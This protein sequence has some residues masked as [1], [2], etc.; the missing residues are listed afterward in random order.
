MSTFLVSVSDKIVFAVLSSP[1]RGVCVPGVRCCGCEKHIS[2]NTTFKIVIIS[3]L[4]VN[5]TECPG[6]Y[7]DIIKMIG[8][9]QLGGVL[10]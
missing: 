10:E 8:K 9:K 7:R 3:V 2:N 1:G 4:F 6:I 5:E